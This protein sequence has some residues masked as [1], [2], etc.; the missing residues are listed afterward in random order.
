MADT[1]YDVLIGIRSKLEEL[2]KAVSGMK[3]LG[4]EVDNVNEKGGILSDTFKQM[5]GALT[6]EKLLEKGIGVIKEAAFSAGDLAREIKFGAENMQMSVRGFQAYQY[7]VGKTGGDFGSFTTAV[8]HMGQALAEARDISSSAFAAFNSANLNPADLE[9]QDLEHRISTVVGALGRMQD[10]QAAVAAEG[11]I[12]GSR[13]LPHIRSALRDLAEDG[14]DKVAAS[15]EKAGKVLSD[16]AIEGLAVKSIGA[17]A[18]SLVK[19]QIAEME[20]KLLPQQTELAERPGLPSADAGRALQAQK[21]QVQ[22]LTDLIGYYQKYESVIS[23]DPTATIASKNASLAELYEK[24]IGLLQQLKVL[25][26]PTDANAMP[27]DP[28]HGDTLPKRTKEVQEYWIALQQLQKQYDALKGPKTGALDRLRDGISDMRSPRGNPDFLRMGDGAQAGMLQWVQSLG[29]E[30][31]QV[32]AVVQSTL[33]GSLAAVSSKLS[34]SDVQSW[35]DVWRNVLRSILQQ[36]IQ[37]SLQLQVMKAIMGIFDL[38]TNVTIGQSVPTFGG[39]PNFGSSGSLAPNLTLGSG[40]ALGGD[41]EVGRMYNIDEAGIPEVFIPRVPGYVSPHGGVALTAKGG[42][43]GGGRT[44]VVNQTVNVSTGVQDT[45]RAE[46]FQMLPTL[47]SMSLDGFLE[48]EAR[49]QL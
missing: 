45:V 26:D 21:A 27:L 30:G 2:E 15:A 43:G 23:N 39:M 42:G 46:I 36:A 19:Y 1:T 22:T 9:A 12:F 3:G 31:Q 28:I 49:N 48:A 4:R 8:Q 40:R 11:V 25:R 41:V 37:L 5:F 47:K 6:A 20:G 29:S 35:G 33:G 38:G 13:T 44:V 17:K 10:R 18:L 24:Q 34:G 14:Y 32:A 7:L 16:R